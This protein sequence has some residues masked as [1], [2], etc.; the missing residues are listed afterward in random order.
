MTVQS[1]VPLPVPFTILI[2]GKEKAPYH[3]NGLRADAACRHRPLI[4]TTEWCHLKTGDY[5][6]KGF[7][8]LV[9][10]ERK[11]LADLFGT[12]GSQ[13]RRD[14]LER[15]HERMSRMEFAAVVIEASWLDILKSP[16]IES[17]LNPKAVF[18]T[19]LH[20]QQRFGVPWMTVDC[21]ELAEAT[22]YRLLEIFYQTHH[23]KTKRKV[24][25]R[26]TGNNIG[27]ANRAADDLD[28]YLAALG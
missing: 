4:I 8:S 21:R 27:P 10:I 3:F 1:E 25:H 28:E 17:S 12:L 13:E 14:R 20:W 16:P 18:R 7:E 19:A 26:E 24:T 15:E 11:S 23:P 22:T 2:D 6:I 5:S 9:T